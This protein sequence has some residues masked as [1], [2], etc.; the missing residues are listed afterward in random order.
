MRF[1]VEVVGAYWEESI[2]KWKVKIRDNSLPYDEAESE[3]YCD[4]LLYA[5]GLLNKW[6]WPDVKGRELFEGRVIHTANWPQ[7]YKQKQWKDQRI[8]VIGS[9]ASSI[10]VVPSMQPYVKQIEVFVRTA[11]EIRGY[12]ALYFFC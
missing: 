10:Q 7:E 12:L 5:T 6:K 9:G 1:N 2:S 4:V 11:S 3:E 8:A